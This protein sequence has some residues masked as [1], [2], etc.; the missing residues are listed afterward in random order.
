M[1]EYKG[2]LRRVVDGDTIDVEIDLGFRM[3]TEQRIRLKG[4]DTPEIYRQ[5]KDSEEYKKGQAAKEFVE[6]RFAENS[7][8]FTIRTDKLPG[9][10]G[11]FIGIFIFDDSDL[12]LNDELLDKGHAEKY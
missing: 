5:K 8:E 9:V 1:Y 11:R 3:K 2:K 4:I 6:R 10:Y 12:S 7:G